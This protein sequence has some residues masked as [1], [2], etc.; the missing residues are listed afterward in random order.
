MWQ[1]R[2]GRKRGEMRRRLKLS[3]EFNPEKC[4]ERTKT[5]AR[6]TRRPTTETRPE[7]FCQQGAF[8]LQDELTHL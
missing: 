1:R 6:G 8:S 5:E 7:T 4:V 2:E 3:L